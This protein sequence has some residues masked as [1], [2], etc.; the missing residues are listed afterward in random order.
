MEL[1]FM[2]DLCRPRCYFQHTTDSALETLYRMGVSSRQITMRIVGIGWKKHMMVDQSPAPG[3]PLHESTEIT[4]SVSGI[5]LFHA[6][7]FGMRE[8]SGEDGPS[9]EE[10]VGLFDDPIEKLRNAIDNPRTL[11][12]LREDRPETCE[13]FIRLFGIDPDTWPKQLWFK[14]AAFL[15]SLH[16][17]GGTERGLRR[18]LRIFLEIEDC[19]IIC[20]TRT[21]ALNQQHY[22]RLGSAF[23]R[24]G[25]DFVSGRELADFPG[26]VIYLGPVSLDQYYEFTERRPALLKRVLDLVLPFHLAYEKD[27]LWIRW[28]VGDSSLKPRLGIAEKNSILGINSHLGAL[29]SAG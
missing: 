7:P 27:S 21:I 17:N 2:P 26:I 1:G 18:A 12:D 23:C 9:T 5:P 25:V 10:I 8:S 14:L 4:L 6:L 28:Q 3:T 15:P 24:L 13:R 11:L 20:R 19:R 29:A 16:R 22:S